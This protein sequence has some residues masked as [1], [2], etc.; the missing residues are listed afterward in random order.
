MAVRLIA[1]ILGL[2]AA[3]ALASAGDTVTIDFTVLRAI[4]VEVAILGADGHVVRHV[5]AG[6]LGGE[7]PAARTPEGGTRAGARM[8]RQR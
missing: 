4:D 5:A 3:G 6:V 8:G 7:E 2:A 1:T